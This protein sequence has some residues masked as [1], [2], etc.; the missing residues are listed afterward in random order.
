MTDALRSFA[1]FPRLS[2][3][4]ATKPTMVTQT[5]NK[6]PESIPG[7]MKTFALMVR[8]DSPAVEN[9]VSVSKRHA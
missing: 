2:L 7:F 1:Y 8:T 3:S 6:F 5:G 9:T 4:L